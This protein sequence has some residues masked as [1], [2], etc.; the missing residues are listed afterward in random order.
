MTATADAPP[1]PAAEAGADRP[2][3]RRDRLLSSLTALPA[4]L[5]LLG[6]FVVP[7]GLILT[8][9]FEWPDW[10]LGSYAE[11]LDDEFYIAILIRTLWI[12]FVVT[13][14][15]AILG[16]PVAYMML[17]AGPRLRGLVILCVILPM[18]TS[19]LVRTYAWIAI[20]GREGLVNETLGFLGLIAEPMDLLYNRLSVYV[21]M[22][23]VMLPFMILPLYAVIQRIDMRLVAAA[24][25][26]GASRTA[27][28]LLV[29]LPL[30]LPG[31]LAGGLLVF[32]L[33][34]GFFVTPAILGGLRETT[35][36]M[37]IERQVNQLFNWELAAAMSI[38]LLLATMAL[39]WLYNR[40]LAER[41]GGFPLVGVLIAR[42]AQARAALVRRVRGTGLAARR[43]SGRVERP[44]PVA[45]VAGTLVLAFLMAPLFV[46]VPLAFSSA[47]F[48]QFPPP[49]FSLRW[50]ET[51][52]T[53]PDWIGPTLTSFQVGGMTMLL[54][55]VVGTLAAVGIVQGRFPGRRIIGAL[56][57]APL[58]VP[59][60]VLAVSLYYLFAQY[61]I[62]GTRGALVLAH[63]VLAVPYVFVVVSAAL[64]RLDPSLGQAASV[65]G[66]NPVR[67]FRHVTLPLIA[68]AVAVAALF[69]FLAS[70]DELVIA[71]FLSGTR[72]ATLPKRMWDAIR[73]EIDPTTA[74]VATLLILLSIAVLA[75]VELIRRRSDGDVPGGMMR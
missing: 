57:L 29:F 51:Y 18:W 58:I 6:V 42:G 41:A 5:L 60:I 47:P 56:L 1:D 15:C 70:F 27:A 23:H 64:Q 44:F 8:L 65:M 7:L 40:A 25:S 17:T 3:E 36:V 52:F 32:I 30:S 16:Y 74:A 53:R 67:V 72:A 61:G 4:A 68:P 37:L 48:L 38:V 26:L 33:S 14:I 20:L 55:T 66:A 12:S 39:V 2:P 45:Q 19:L 10:S 50:F 11:I 49:G 75:V 22:T 34:L 54:S 62:I 43:R 71:L 35:F 59:T 24:T 46:V 73:E 9:S 21:G 69:A 28:F 13:L 63:S 31:I